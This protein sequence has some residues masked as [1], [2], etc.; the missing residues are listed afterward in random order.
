MTVFRYIARDKRWQLISLII[1]F[2][3]GITLLAMCF[4]KTDGFWGTLG[5][6]FGTTFS[7]GAVVSLFDLLRTSAETM[8]NEAIND[9]ISLGVRRIYPHRDLDEYYK[10]LKNARSIDI[11]GYS[12]RGFF[13]SHENTI[14]ELSK[15]KGFRLRIVMVD[16]KSESS[17]SREVVE[18]GRITGQ[19]ELGYNK[20]L[21]NFGSLNGVELYT[22]PFALSTMIFRIDNIMYVGPHFVKEASKTSLTF[23]LDSSGRAFQQFQDEFEALIQKG[24]RIPLD[25][26]NPSDSKLD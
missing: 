6:A 25:T 9:I 10:L 8:S 4:D 13:Q 23:K 22:I 19:F 26:A 16:P 24:K 1:L 12:L 3:I 17:R 21:K 2:L 5:V 7:A 14:I 11:T 15:R 20:I 18:D